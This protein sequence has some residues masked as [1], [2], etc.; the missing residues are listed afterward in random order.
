[1]RKSNLAK[2]LIA[3]DKHGDVNLE[4]NSKTGLKT[5]LNFLCTLK[6]T[7]VTFDVIFDAL[8][9]KGANPLQRRTLD[10]LPLHWIAAENGKLHACK[11]L[12][13]YIPKEHLE[14]YTCSRTGASSLYVAAQNGHSALVAF[15]L[16][17]QGFDPNN[18]TTHSM[19]PLIACVG[20]AKRHKNVKEIIRIARLLLDAGADPLAEY[21]KSKHNALESASYEEVRMVL[22]QDYILRGLFYIERYKKL[23]Q[24]LTATYKQALFDWVESTLQEERAVF[25]ALFNETCDM[26]TSFQSE[27]FGP[28]AEELASMVVVPNATARSSL[29][30]LEANKS[31]WIR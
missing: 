10:N 6:V 23:L 12:F 3:L 25:A 15:L 26:E 18:I 28:V 16:T 1:M 22:F 2:F 17:E 8:L 14:T 31:E 13:H 19:T 7:N 9:A 27:V 29:R 21:N 30:Y 4:Y 20:D 5:P 11:R 24:G